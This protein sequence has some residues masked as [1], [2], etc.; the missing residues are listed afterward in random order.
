MRSVL[1]LSQPLDGFRLDL[2]CELISS[3]RHV[4]GSPFRVF[5]SRRA[6]H[7]SMASALM[8]SLPLCLT[9]CAVRQ[10][11]NPSSGLCSLRESVVTYG[12]IH[13]ADT[14]YPLG[15]F[16]PRVFLPPAV[17]SASAL[18]PSRAFRSSAPERSTSGFFQTGSSTTLLDVA[19]P[20]EVHHLFTSPDRSKAFATLAYFLT[21]EFAQ[22]YGQ[23]VNSSSGHL[24]SLPQPV[25]NVF[26]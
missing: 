5:P 20:S 22:P 12:V 3:R 14:R 16:L 7:L 9:T 23:L 25:R 4:R 2:P 10:R 21:L 13:T 15:L 24:R 17:E 11:S 26:R 8:P 18:L 6:V 19:D 1:R